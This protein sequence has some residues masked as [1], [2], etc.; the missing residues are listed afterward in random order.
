MGITVMDTVSK[1]RTKLP[2]FIL[3]YLLAFPSFSGDWQATPRVNIDEVLT[4]NV[5]LNEF[6]KSSSAVTIFSPGLNI[7]YLATGAEL[8]IDY[9]LSQAWY[10]HDHDLDDDFNTLKANGRLSLPINGLSLIGSASITNVS[11]NTARNSLADIVSGDTVEYKNYSLGLT[12]NTQS[13]SFSIDSKINFILDDAQDDVGER[14][15]YNA[16][17]LSVSGSNSR[18]V[19]WYLNGEYTDYQND[20]RDG[21]FYTSEIKVGYISNPKINPFIRV[22]DEDVSGN[23]NDNKIQGT[24]SI[25]VGVRWLVAEHF[26][27]DVAYNKVDEES[28]SIGEVSD[29]QEDY[30]SAAI[31]WQPS[32]RT[33]IYAKYY[34]RFFGD[35][36]EFNYSH[37]TRRLTTS[38]AYNE[39]LNLFDRLE[40]APTNYQDVWCLSGQP[41]NIDNCL[42]SPGDDVDLSDYD[43]SGIYSELELQQAESFSL[44]QALTLSSQLSLNRMSLQLSLGK[45]KREN[46]ELEDYDSYD[47]ASFSIVRQT[48]RN[49]TMTLK[50]SFNKNSL[51]NN[52]RYSTKQEDYYRIYSLNWQHQLN[53]TL[54]V[55]YSGQHLNR[56]SNHFGYSYEENRLSLLLVK[57]F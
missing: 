52:S 24:S 37:R 43:F 47:T 35:A 41:Q 26:V 33:N 14:D 19:F 29:E 36:Y 18:Y 40:L 42:F 4:D 5:E 27:V 32:A 51:N 8:D 46:L 12:Y 48:S 39:S 49:A 17:F 13:S 7:N 21:S 23:L 55:T 31:E 6:D 3:L 10:S 2:V 15:G 25:G 53:R 54:Q 22:Y 16:S 44:N 1:V 45:R 28:D 11:Q 20:S 30:T 50:L 9:S 56:A 57:E 34:Q 38:V